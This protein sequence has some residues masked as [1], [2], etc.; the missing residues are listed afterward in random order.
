MIEYLSKE[1]NDKYEYIIPS[2]DFTK[3]TFLENNI[4]DSL[5]FRSS[6]NYR[7]Y[8]TNVYEMEIINDFIQE[9]Q[10]KIDV[11]LILLMSQ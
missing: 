10:S 5:S 7:K 2:Y 3:E 4:F 9:S 1:N 8:N 6:G 11:L